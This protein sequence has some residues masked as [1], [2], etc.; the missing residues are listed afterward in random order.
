VKIAINTFLN[1]KKGF[2]LS[3]WQDLSI[4]YKLLFSMGLSTCLFIITA[5]LVLLLLQNIWKD[6]NLVKEKGEQAVLIS[7]IGT[8]INAKDIRIA[9]Y[10][11]FLKVDD[12][13]KFREY[14][15]EMNQKLSGLE[16]NTTGI[17]KKTMLASIRK[18][19]ERIDNLFIKVVVPS[20]VRLDGEIYTKARKEISDLRDENVKLLTKLSKDVIEERDN[21]VLKAE[22]RMNGFVTQILIT[23]LF[24]TIFSG[25]IVFF[26]SQTLRNTLTKIA[27]TA[28][29]VSQ[30]DLN[31][32]EISYSGKDEIGE[33]T[34]SINTMTANL[35]GMVNG[36]IHASDN[37]LN[38]SQQ[39]H[40]YCDNVK[41]SSGDITQTMSTLSLGAE[42]QATSTSQLISHYDSFDNQIGLSAK[43]GRLLEQSSVNVMEITVSGQNLM[44][45][46]VEEITAIFNTIQDTYHKVVQMEKKASDINRLAEVIQSIASQTHLLALN[47]AIEAAR[48]GD[49]GKG[50]AVVANEVKKLAG[51]VQLSLV[52]INEIVLS[53]QNMSKHV[54]DSLL[55]GY[56]GLKSGTHTIKQTRDGFHALRIEIEKMAT[57][58]IDIY[59]YLEIVTNSSNEVKS[60][61]EAIAATSQQFTSGASQTTSSIQVQDQDL[62]N[63]LSQANEMTRQ[64]HLLTSL[65]KNFKL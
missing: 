18:N 36:I 9:D 14:R 33:I 10:I 11:T 25:L 1:K 20:V 45:N 5:L 57:N 21:S 58:A 55:K 22:N 40:N 61:F 29:R 17:E 56:E 62:E 37:I 48:A 34:S 60:S 35:R 31:V 43:T 49:L 65:V 2:F 8:I 50:F 28:K 13:K 24:S 23:V 46:S 42:Q 44:D 15:N 7:D 3:K 59:K 19:N 53:V 41:K 12:V 6:I 38:N 54:S 4:R 47:A 27:D 64:A 32:E 39:L 26:L 51:G 16:K 30:G 63:I 52:E